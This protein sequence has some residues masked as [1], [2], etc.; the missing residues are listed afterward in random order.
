M[1]RIREALIYS[2]ASQYLLK[3]LNFISIAVFARLLTPAEL[4]ILAIASSA[5]LI[6]SE[7]RLLGTTNY[8]VREKEIS[9]SK[10]QSGI[11]LTILISWG[12]GILILS[13]SDNIADFYELPE[14]SN[15]FNIL[16]INFFLAPFIS[17][18]SSILTRELKF[19]K[20]MLINFLSEIT[21]FVASL[22]LVLLGFSYVGLAWGIL[23]GSVLEL[24]LLRLYKTEMTSWKPSF[25]NL[26][27]IVKF[28]LFSS[29]CNLLARFDSTAPDLIIG[30]LGSAT[31]AA[32]FSK[33]VGLLT[34][35]TQLI[36]AGIWP[37]ALPYLSNV[38]RDNG[39]VQQ[40]YIKAA[41]LLG[42]ICWPVIAV[43]GVVSYP[44]IM[45][46]FGE[47][48]ME[49]IPLVSVLSIWGVL[50]I[51]HTLS[52]SL[53]I[54]T[55]H[56]KLLLVKQ[57]AI[58]SI[59]IPSLYYGFQQSG[60]IGVAWAM[61]FVGLMDF[62]ISGLAVKKAINLSLFQFIWGMRLNILLCGIC[63]SVVSMLDYFIIFE[64]ILPIVSFFILAFTMPICW[65]LSVKYLNHP[66]Y[67]EIMK[68]LNPMQQKIIRKFKS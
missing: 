63:W 55:G 23:I 40:A 59:T 53:L 54:T 48:W 13:T 50:R 64:S 18:T 25:Q 22:G 33:G 19:K 52:P 41:L 32:L 47:Q 37:V 38:K 21:R 26:K 16:S 31:Q 34:Y 6:A 20:L 68:I 56:E 62:V 12:L 2:S 17:V 60:L 42:A 4:G 27:P 57:I 66:I 45:L 46:V 14:L 1:S 7:L 35:L 29:F 49:S 5:M 51:V 58:F 24:L 15:V 30:K 44:M 8:L 3:L 67:S 36:S 65:L 9:K 43:A 11:G 39:D 61:A 28:G 10:I